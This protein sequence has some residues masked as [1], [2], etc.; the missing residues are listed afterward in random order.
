M[1]LS[2][3]VRRLAL[4]VHVVVSVAFPGAVLSFLALA[5]LALVADPATAHIAYVAMDRVTVLVIVPLCLATLVTGVVSSLGTP[6][7][8][9]RYWWVVV[10]LAGTVVAT[11]VLVMHLQ[12]I[13]MMA[14][15]PLG[16]DMGKTPAQL[17]VAAGAALGALVFMTALSV[18]KPRGLTRYGAS[19]R[20]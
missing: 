4:T 16:A 1:Q 12:P 13:A 7:G 8:L 15:A 14:A 6:W 9:L 5:L 18:Y 17:A 19:V 10:K 3:S 2:A 20:A 11:A